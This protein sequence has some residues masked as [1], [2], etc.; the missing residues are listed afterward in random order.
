METKA[1]VELAKMYVNGTL[2]KDFSAKDVTPSEALRKGFYELLEVEVGQPISPKTFRKHKN[3]VFEILEEVIEITINEGFT[4]VLDG[5]IDYRNLALGDK[6]EFYIP[7]NSYFRV[8]VISDGNGNLRRQRHREGERFSV[9]TV[10]RGVKIYEEFDRFMAGRVDFMEMARKVGES[11]VKSIKEDIYEAILKNFREGGAGEPYRLSLT[12]GLPT[13]KQ[14]L[15]VA[16]HLEARTGAEV[17]IYGT[18]LALSNLDIKY[19]SDASNNQ[20][21]QQAF[22]GRIAGIE[23]KELPA[24]HKEGT[25][26][27]IFEDDAILLLPQTNDKFVKV[28]NEG[29]AYVEE[30]ESMNRDDL[31]KEYLLTQKLGIATVPS[32]QFGF[33]KFKAN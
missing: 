20:R 18:A 7:D 8:S 31:Q 24:L 29:E 27:F 4:D 5:L 21:N 33:I 19:P 28:V 3:E 30:G 26:D 17:V 23:A 14:I 10:R 32:S 16:K 22:Y 11:M 12:G 6:N 25:T 1:L 15:E 9:P 2:P 13:E